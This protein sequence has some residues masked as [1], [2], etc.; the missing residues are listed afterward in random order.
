V[1]LDGG[2]EAADE[3]FRRLFAE[4]VAALAAVPAG[5]ESPKS[6][7]QLEAMR[8]FGGEPSYRIVSRRG[9][10]SATTFVAEAAVADLAAQGEGRS[11]RA[12]ETAAAAA[13]L[14]K[15]RRTAGGAP[16]NVADPPADA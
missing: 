10:D 6:A 16:A 2:P 11:K 15:L 5:G 7:L 9:P 8:R 3:V 14:A 1:L 13:L 12:A 4:D